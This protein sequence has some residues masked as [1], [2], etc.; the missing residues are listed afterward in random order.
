MKCKSCMTVLYGKRSHKPGRQAQNKIQ[1]L[2]GNKYRRLDT[3][4]THCRQL[5]YLR[6]KTSDACTTGCQYIYN[7]NKT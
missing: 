1:K 2:N 5:A 6:H 7:S 3:T 4:T